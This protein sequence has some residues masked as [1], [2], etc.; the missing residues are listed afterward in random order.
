MP[1]IRNRKPL[2]D[3]TPKNSPIPPKLYNPGSVKPLPALQL[4][5]GGHHAGEGEPT[6]PAKPKSK[7]SKAFI[8]ELLASPSPLKGKKPS[9][10]LESTPRLIKHHRGLALP[11]GS[12]APRNVRQS[13]PTARQPFPAS[14]LPPSS[15]PSTSDIEYEF[16]QVSHELTYEE[17]EEREEEIDNENVANVAHVS[18]NHSGGSSKS[19]EDPF[20]ILAAEKKL[21]AQRKQE[22]QTVKGKGKEVVPRAPLGVLAYASPESQSP[23]PRA[24]S[25]RPPTPSENNDDDDDDLYADPY[26]LDSF[27]QAG[28]SR[29]QHQQEPTFDRE[30]GVDDDDDET[31]DKENAPPPTEVQSFPFAEEEIPTPPGTPHPRHID[32]S[33]F[34][35]PS[36]FSSPSTPCNRDLAIDSTESTPSPTKPLQVITP[37]RHVRPGPPSSA[38]KGKGRMSFPLLSSTARDSVLI[39]PR[40]STPHDGESIRIGPPS[41]AAHR[42]TVIVSALGK[43]KAE[44][45][46]KPAPRKRTRAAATKKENDSDPMVV[47]K[48]LEELLPKKPIRRSARASAT[49]QRKAKE[50]TKP[51]A[52]RSTRASAKTEPV[53]VDSSTESNAG[54]EAE[55]SEEEVGVGKRRKAAGRG[56]PPAKKAKAGGKKPAATRVRKPA[57]NAAKSTKA[58]GK[59]KQTHVDSDEDS[60]VVRQRQSRIDYFKKLDKDYNLAQEN[61]YV[62]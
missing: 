35:L 57:S 8:E 54:D 23:L 5:H 26:I 18:S 41:S 50:P 22:Q 13:F 16:L 19:S 21:K 12:P 53:V 32:P 7:V 49:T 34:P 36:P 14:P 56:R 61:V 17:E 59:Q 45:E 6:F 44:Q 60:E 1:N 2:Q 3:K 33:R 4:P 40:S 43:R 15:P 37:L 47:A 25:K 46:V 24:V 62:V 42:K 20:G 10:P 48:N 38:L 28:P 9:G 29:M 55:T 52:R 51:V 58:K 11:S 27:D 30:D 31:E 39:E